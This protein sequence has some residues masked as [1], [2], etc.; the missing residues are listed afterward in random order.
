MNKHFILSLLAILFSLALFAQSN[1]NNPTQ[2]TLCPDVY[3]SQQTN[4]NLLDDAPASFNIAGEDVVYQINVPASTTRL[5]ISVVNA[6]GPYKGSLLKNSCTNSP[7]TSS[8]NL[9]GSRNN[10]Y[11]IS[12]STT[13]F[14]WIDAASTITYDIAFGADTFSGNV[15][16]PN[17]KG[18]LKFDTTNCA[19]PFFNTTKPFFNVSYN[20]I[21]QMNPMTL[22]PLGQQGT[23]CMSTF[24]QNTTGIEAIKQFTFKFDSLGYLNLNCI[25]SIPGF[26]AA[27]Y[28]IKSQVGN[29]ITYVFKDSLHTGKGDFNVVPNTCLKYKFCF[30]ITPI[31]NN[32]AITN[33]IITILSDGKGAGYIGPLVGGCCPGPN[34]NCHG[35]GSGGGAA[36]GGTGFGFGISDPGNGSLP[37]E[38]VDFHATAKSETVDLSWETASETNNDFFTI[39]RSTEGQ[40]WGKIKTIKGAGNTSTEKRYTSTDLQPKVGISYYRLKQTDFNGNFS[41]SIIRDVRIENGSG[42]SIYP[43]PANNELNI[44]SNT[45]EQFSIK[46]LNNQGERISVNM[47]EESNQRRI[48]TSLLSNGI[49][50]LIIEEGGRIKS[51]KTISVFR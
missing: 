30:N 46:M 15:N 21:Y 45:Q 2:V 26:Y 35:S 39:E 48:D 25:D 40:V 22:S 36:S 50:F 44:V 38:L 27:G 13:Y 37:I 8:T 7:L 33:V 34:P 10:T 49:Y 14:Y 1:C 28:W 19:W 32:P 24:F 4:A 12:G 47:I 16:I 51:G 41:Y 17:T 18:N 3:L 42:Y 43:N 31:S 6:S 11:N 9:S 20:G 29:L 5:H 23:M